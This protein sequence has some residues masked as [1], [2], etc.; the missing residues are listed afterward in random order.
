VMH[1]KKKKRKREKNKSVSTETVVQPFI[2][3]MDK[4]EL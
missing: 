4:E 2:G 3:C 1:I